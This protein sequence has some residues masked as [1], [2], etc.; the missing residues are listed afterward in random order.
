[1]DG[2]ASDNRPRC[3]SPRQ[4][5]CDVGYVHSLPVVFDRGRPDLGPL[6]TSAE[7]SAACGTAITSLSEVQA[8]C[9]G[10]MQMAWS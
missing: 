5:Q 7:A 4:Q 8:T 3:L 6:K 1:M 2:G 9:S 10:R